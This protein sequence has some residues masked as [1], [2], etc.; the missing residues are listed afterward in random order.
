L[1]IEIK[2]I[3]AQ[4]TYNLRHEV[5]WPDKPLDFVKLDNDEE[6][7]YLLRVIRRSSENW[8]LKLQNKVR[9]MQHFYCDTSQTMLWQKDM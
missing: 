8:L 4:E 6:G 7:L 1:H 9:G 2:Q 3:T 5:M